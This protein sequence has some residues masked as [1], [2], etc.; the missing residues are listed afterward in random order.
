[1]K[2]LLTLAFIA[3]ALA[4]GSCSI[5]DED[6]NPA[7][8]DNNQGQL[9]DGSD[10]DDPQSVPDYSHAIQ[11]RWWV[12]YVYCWED[13]DWDA[14][15]GYHREFAFNPDGTGHETEYVMEITQDKERPD[16]KWVEQ[17]D[18]HR[19]FTYTATGDTIRVKYSDCTMLYTVE[20][21]DEF[22]T[23]YTDDRDD[24]YKYSRLNRHGA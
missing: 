10:G 2:K 17:T 3:A 18:K 6:E 12:Y 13:N 20:F 7:H 22:M 24:D 15:A 5:G 16:V 4:L 8:D 1:M 11:G 9:P 19:D 23:L 21:D 14:F